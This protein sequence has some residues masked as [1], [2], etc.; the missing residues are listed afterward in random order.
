MALAWLRCP[1]TKAD[2]IA[3]LYRSRAAHG[4]VDTPHVTTTL[5]VIKVRPELDGDTHS[6][7][8]P[9]LIA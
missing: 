4:L 6:G 1:T 3:S 9:A 8:E 2:T 7:L 5:S